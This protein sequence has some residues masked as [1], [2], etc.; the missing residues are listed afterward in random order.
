M[1]IRAR[2]AGVEVGDRRPPAIMGIINISS[3]SFY[4]GSV[5][6]GVEEALALAQRM[7]EEG[8]D[9][10]DIG[11]MSTNPK[12]PMLSEDEE[13]RRLVPVLE[14]L[15][16]GVEVPIS[17]DTQRATIAG[18]AL[19]IG[20]TMINDVS[21]FRFDPG[22]AGVAADAGCPVVLMATRKV[23]GDALTMEEIITALK[24]SIRLGEEAGVR[25]E[26]IVVDPGIGLWVPEKKTGYNLEIL[27][28]LGELRVLG[29]PVLV[30]ISRKS[31]IGTVLGMEDPSERLYGSLSA[32]A[33]AVMEG[34]HIIRTHD[35]EETM[36]VARM[37]WAIKTGEY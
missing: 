35:I 1:E 26:N 37:A 4:Q 14:A 16:D 3:E 20:A 12:A 19:K 21:A 25:P 8:A 2:I 33:I 28:R 36:E 6:A 24:E 13:R 31:F 5:A 27:R 22:M 23:R 9:F 34:A 18:E 29:R 32:T 10:I 15:V 17:V 11:A 7:E 30:G